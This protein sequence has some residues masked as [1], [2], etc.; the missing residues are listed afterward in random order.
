MKGSS[1]AGCTPECLS[2][3][4]FIDLNRGCVARDKDESEE[5][6]SIET[7]EEGDEEMG[8]MERSLAGHE[9]ICGVM[10]SQ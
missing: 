10:I 2:P 9:M 5:I 1:F 4:T 3:G 6:E 8:E 7:T